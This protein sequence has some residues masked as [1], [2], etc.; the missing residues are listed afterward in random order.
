M[1]PFKF[2][3]I[4]KEKIWGGRNIGRKFARELPAGSI[5][6]SWEISCHG[7]DISEVAN[8]SYAG[9]SLKELI[10]RHREEIL[11]PEL[12]QASKSGARL[13]SNSV[14]DLGNFFPLL[15]KIIDARDNLSVQV[16][17]DDAYA[18][19]NEARA[20]GK[21]EL[22]YILNAEP[23]ARIIYGLKAEVGQ[24]EFREA[25]GASRIQETL[26]EVRVQTG[27][28]F[29]IPAGTV[30]AIGEGVMLAEIQQN[31]D[32]TYRV[33]DW[34]R[35]DA[36]GN[37]REL[38]IEKAF[39]AIDF[40]KGFSAGETGGKEVLVA[41][42]D[43][44]LSELISTNFFDVNLLEVYKRHQADTEG[45]RFYIYLNLGSQVTLNYAGGSMKVASGETVLIPAALGSYELVGQSRLL[46]AFVR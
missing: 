10:S 31:S 12:G 7:D 41:N 43:F 36:D 33:Y 46:K 26:N 6:E 17:P 4:Y 40:S 30:H 29:Y 25:V 3:P 45:K 32:L 37:S 38:H 42:Q 2:K 19:E 22:W 28:Y 39:E 1:Y 27:D 11:G 44:K 21:T 13:N 18:A 20:S 34:D 24:E 5:G 23:G 16:H 9:L 14:P 8:G 35:T 15:V